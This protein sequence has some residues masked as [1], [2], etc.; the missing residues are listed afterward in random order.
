MRPD[1]F[2]RAFIE[3]NNLIRLRN[4]AEVM[5]NDNKGLAARQLAYC[6]KVWGPM[7]PLMSSPPFS[8]SA[9]ANRGISFLREV[10]RTASIS[11]SA[12][13]P[14]FLAL[15]DFRRAE[16][17]VDLLKGG[18]Q[19]YLIAMLGRRLIITRSQ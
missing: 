5:R 8:I 19:V 3:D 16:Q 1:G 7:P 14:G 12:R 9:Q 4:G 15:A 6:F 10:L 18:R 11:S 2:D 13:L 17:G